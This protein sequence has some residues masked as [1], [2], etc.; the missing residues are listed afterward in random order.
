MTT[1]SERT[2]RTYVA[3]QAGRHLSLAVNGNQ[4]R[5]YDSKFLEVGETIAHPVGTYI[6]LIVAEPVE[7]DLPIYASI[8]DSDEHKHEKQASRLVHTYGRAGALKAVQKNV[9]RARSDEEEAF[10]ERVGELIEDL[11]R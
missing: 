2:M 9:G 3:K 10:W 4:F 7:D 11:P 1:D 8:M 6:L 5:I